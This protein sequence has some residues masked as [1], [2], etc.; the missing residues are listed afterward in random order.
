M[1]S[2]T[3][4]ERTRLKRIPQR[5]VHDR[6]TIYRILDEGLICHVG[7]VHEGT[8]CVVPTIHWRQ[9][10]RLYLHGSVGARMFKDA[11]EGG[12]DLCITV[13]LLDGLVLARS[14]FHHSMNY[15][16]VMV[17]GR[18]RLVEDEAE[19]REA[20]DALVDHVIPGRSAQSRAA[21]DREM[22]QT[23]VLAI[24][25][26]EASA[27]IRAEGVHDD[28]E[29]M[30]GP[31]WAGVIPLR[32]VPGAPVAEPDLKPGIA[33]PENALCYTRPGWDRAV[34]GEDSANGKGVS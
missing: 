26:E 5:G 8:P 25:L 3:A 19:K 4:T 1:S 33:T 10:D 17:F 15:R 30:D 22:R 28:K 23:A 18:G 27:K 2:L 34:F 9:G 16:S 20:F 31:H 29:D 7:F 11:A 6:D 24:P 21:N 32:I 14:A 12:L 13:T